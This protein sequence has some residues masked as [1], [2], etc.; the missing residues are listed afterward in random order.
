MMCWYSTSMLLFQFR[1]HPNAN[2]E[3]T[4]ERGPSSIL[5]SEYLRSSALW[6]IV[7]VR[8]QLQVKKKLWPVITVSDA[9]STQSAAVVVGN[10]WPTLPL[11]TRHTFECML[12]DVSTVHTSYIILNNLLIIILS[13]IIMSYCHI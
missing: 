7:L 4:S 11:P 12:T 5:F 13:N 10:R 9:S 1:L 6:R 3:P 8:I 2:Q